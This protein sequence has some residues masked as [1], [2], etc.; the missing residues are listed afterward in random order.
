MQRSTGSF[1]SQ[2]RWFYFL[3]L[4]VSAAVYW[5][6]FGDLFLHLNT[7]LYRAEGDSLKNYYTYA[8]HG[9]IDQQALYLSGLNYPHGEH[10]VYTDCQPLLS[11]F[12]RLLP[13]CANHLVGI[14][15]GFI[16]LS[17]VVTPLLLLRVLI[18]LGTAPLPSMLFALS[19]AL[20]A[21]Q[22]HR[23][24]GHFALAG[25]FVIPLSIVLLLRYVDKPTTTT[26]LLIAVYNTAL[27]F[28]HPYLGLGG[29]GFFTVALMSYA[30]LQKQNIYAFNRLGAYLAGGALPVVFFRVF[31][32]ATDGR[33]D[34]PDEPWGSDIMDGAATIE[35]VFSPYYGPFA[36]LAKSFFQPGPVEWETRAYVGIAPLLVGLVLLLAL[37]FLL[38]KLQLSKLTLALLIVS[39]LFLLFSF[40]LHNLL[41]RALHLEVTALSQFRVVGR[42]AWYF[43]FLMPV[44]LVTC[45]GQATAAIFKRRGTTWLTGFALLYLSLTAVEAN[46]FYRLVLEGNFETKNLFNRQLLTPEE[47][48]TLALIDSLHPQAILPLPLFHI[49]S[50]VYQRNGELSAA[51][52]MFYSFHSRVPL[53]SNMQ[54]R[55]S[56]KETETLL[57]V[58][59]I[60]KKHRPILTET[61]ERP[62]LV[63]QCSE[64]LQPD[65]QRLVKRLRPVHRLGDL[66]FFVA[67]K[68][69]LL[70]SPAEKNRYFLLDTASQALPNT[71]YVPQGDRPPYREGPIEKFA[72][73][74]VLPAN[75][76]LPGPYVVSFHYHLKG[77]KLRYLS[78]GLIVEKSAP[79]PS[80]WKYY[81]TTR[82]S[83]GIYDSIVVFENKIQLEKNTH[84]SFIL[85]GGSPEN[86][87]I[88]DFLL[89]PDTLNV[90]IRK[91]G[92]YT[93]NNYPEY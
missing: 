20:L 22:I 11:G 82:A 65:E 87:F 27:F 2:P 64:D 14:M 37:P 92:T 61:D 52:A 88:S 68:E 90:K 17:F 76:L 67:H 36:T 53:L 21:P 45:L 50:E 85:N 19:I 41:L 72:T 32:A 10:I 42:F 77:K 62:F 39:V 13:F 30:L 43:Y 89:R 12:L 5:I 46:A 55:T 70:C 31:M 47:K 59:N 51:P 63:M 86:Y 60:Y 25:T 3:L 56:L 7:V 44:V 58:L 79:P 9:S 34:R 28:V 6:Y 18:R 48:R 71:V 74:Y 57:E 93:Y 16:L 73:A 78:N 40:G 54:S 15:H 69:D 66:T 23:I 29:C 83:S 1:F 24:G 84:Y 80:E 49:G 4:A 38:K 91:N 81:L 8:W 26:L 75:K 33:V 35:S